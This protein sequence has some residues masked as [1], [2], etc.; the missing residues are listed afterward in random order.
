MQTP[1]CF[2]NGLWWFLLSA[3][4][5]RE[6]VCEEDLSLPVPQG[7]TVKPD[8]QS[9]ILSVEWED[10][11]SFRSSSE[12]YEIE[13]LLTEKMEV[14]HRDVYKVL[15]NNTNKNQWM[16]ISPMPLNCTSHSLRIRSIHN[17]KKSKWSSLVTIQG[18]D[19]KD[20]DETAV[21]P[22][23]RVVAVG[24]N[25]TFCCVAGKK[26]NVTDLSF[27]G[28]L[29]TTYL[30]NRTLA[31]QKKLPL[32][33][34]SSGDNVICISPSSIGGTVVFVGYAPRDS[35][36]VCETR[37]LASVE[38][39]WN[40]GNSTY[41][42]GPRR[43][44]Y[45]LTER[46][47]GEG[48][49]S[50]AN[51]IHGQ[52]YCCK[53]VVSPGQQ[54]YVFTLRA[55]NPLGAVELSDSLDLHHRGHIVA[56]AQ[57]ASAS[58]K[59]WTS[60]RLVWDWPK[61]Y[62]RL[63]FVC[64]VEMYSQDHAEVRNYTLDKKSS[65]NLEMSHLLPGE[66]YSVRVRCGV[67]ED[68]WKWGDWSHIKQFQTLEESPVKALDIWRNIIKEEDGQKVVIAWKPLSKRESN[69]KIR[70]YE[71]TWKS[72]TDGSEQSFTLPPSDTSAELNLSN[73]DYVISVRASN[74]AGSSPPSILIVPELLLVNNSVPSVVCAANG[75]FHLSWS[76]NASV[77]CGYIV[78]WC[79]THRLQ[80]CSLYW[81][82]VPLGSTNAVIKSEDFKPGVQYS[83]SIYG[84]TKNR[85]YLLERK[86]GYG[87]ELVFKVPSEPVKNL[88]AEPRS[89]NEVLLQWEDI[90][91]EKKHGFIKGFIIYASN[92]TGRSIIAA[93]IT[94]PDARSY[95]LKRL[96]SSVY[97][98]TVKAYT[99]AGEDDGGATVS[100]FMPGPT[101]GLIAIILISL[102]VMAVSSIIL[103]VVCYKKRN[104]VMQ[105]FYP[106]IPKP[107]I[108]GEQWIP[109]EGSFVN[110]P[111]NVDACDTSHV[112]VVGDVL[113]EQ[114]E[115]D[116]EEPVVDD[117][118]TGCSSQ[119]ILNYYGQVY[120]GGA[121]TSSLESN[122]T[123]VTY[124]NIQPS[125]SASA[126]SGYQP[127][128]TRGPDPEELGPPLAM[129]L[130]CDPAG[131][132]PQANPKDW[133]VESP[134]PASLN[135]SLGSPTSINSTQFLLPDQGPEDSQEP[136]FSTWFHN[137]LSMKR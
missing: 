69:G 50:E 53:H 10:D 6:S 125:S 78:D 105:T 24:T 100:V 34:I 28:K 55:V 31:A 54:Q 47:S 65:W 63:S 86:I 127:Q 77:D 122:S 108:R 124:T 2:L 16:W 128:M 57:K 135:S 70:Q 137:F 107:E 103:T 7:V 101:D 112:C 29:G 42:Y 120:N 113:V 119:T 40:T 123:E 25:L 118:D 117:N 87:Q 44:I 68:F 36:L 23:D 67:A 96:H 79:P 58:C 111:M 35:D 13:V 30:S 1:L 18:S 133:T 9:D 11:S 76:P 134:G 46:L 33:S 83:F 17:H 26:D 136:Q 20:V 102:G 3:V 115:S 94:N 38:C 130:I 99:A 97:N 93:N 37:D 104:W 15:L 60:A 109:G 114:K 121:G 19:T 85:P 61:N 62:D 52:K 88:K 95:V 80:N 126:S 71:V 75:G 98:F 43:T 81:V 8:Y 22:I 129:P 12:Q 110:P 56:E 51:V 64:Q 84:C 74:S 32:P 82:K 66:K 14:V 39:Y 4:L 92:K 132:Q 5:V 59:T 49:C 91:L 131:Y 21:F 116:T 72:L 41:L 45:S 106:D 89:A 73:R 27:Q 90:P 48:N